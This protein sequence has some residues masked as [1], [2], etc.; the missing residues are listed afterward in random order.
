MTAA[1]VV[2][3][4]RAR[5]HERVEIELD[6]ARWRVVPLAAVLRAELRV[7]ARL[8]RRQARTLARELRRRR[9]LD[10]ALGALA[11]R[12]HTVASLDGRLA[13]H[14]IAERDRD[15][16][17]GVVERAGLVDDLRFARDRAEALAA[18]GAGDRMIA[19]DLERHG[20]ASAATAQALEALEAE[21]A[22]VQRLV[23]RRGASARTL[24]FLAAR[25]FSEESLEPLIA[26]LQEGAVG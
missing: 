21:P 24:R 8:E 18:R 1:R 2:T 14:G 3:A 13:A 17:L 19:E 15:L 5:G 10:V 11:R 7:G 26:R 22:R 4:L 9:A 12:D 20:L 6:G 16:A 23:E 25:G